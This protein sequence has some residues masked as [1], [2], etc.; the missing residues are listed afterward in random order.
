MRHSGTGHRWECPPNSAWSQSLLISWRFLLRWL[1]LG[2]WCGPIAGVPVVSAATALAGWKMDPESG[3]ATWRDDRVELRLNMQTASW[4]VT[5]PGNESI[6]LQGVSSSAEVD[7]RRVD[8]ET[9]STLAWKQRDALGRY[10]ELVMSWETNGVEIVRELR[11]Y[12]S[13]GIVTIGGR[14]ANRSGKEVRL[15]TFQLL[16]L[17][18]GGRW[19]AGG[20]A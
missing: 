10:A 9:A 8:L 11:A 1:V 3:K 19:Q 2:L 18:D 13:T 15:G 4:D 6:S 17:A 5:W 20:K 16:R 12:G 14:V 7:G